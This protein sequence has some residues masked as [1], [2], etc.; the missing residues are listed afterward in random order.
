MRQYKGRPL[1]AALFYP[2]ADGDIANVGLDACLEPK[3]ATRYERFSGEALISN[4]AVLWIFRE[5]CPKCQ[6]FK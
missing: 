1:R 3:V 6:S 2:W 5:E 4:R